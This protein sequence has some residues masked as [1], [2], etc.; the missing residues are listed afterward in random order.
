MLHL[1]ATGAGM[2]V[3]GYLSAPRGLSLW[4]S[5]AT[6]GPPSSPCPPWGGYAL[7]SPLSSP[8]LCSCAPSG[9]G[10][11]TPVTQ[12]TTLRAPQGP[13][14]PLLP[15]APRP[16]VT[17]GMPISNRLFWM[18]CLPSMMMLSWIQSSI[19][20]PPGAHCGIDNRYIKPL[21]RPL[22]TSGEVTLAPGKGSS[23]LVLWA[24]CV[25]HK[26]TSPS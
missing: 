13:I 1:L 22:W 12:S 6:S 25:P 15:L 9:P 7:P 8:R 2:R 23:A 14:S 5:R 19:R 18:S 3:R 20:Q 11:T 26:D 24:E 10:P 4:R 21:P 17:H 16:D